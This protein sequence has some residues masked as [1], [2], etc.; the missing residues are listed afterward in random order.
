MGLDVE[1]VARLARLKL[2]TA[3]VELLGKQLESVLS[4][5]NVLK[6]VNIEGVPPTTHV[7]PLKNIFREDEVKPS[8]ASEDVLK[9]APRK[10]GGFFKVPPILKQ[11]S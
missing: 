2:N 7:L 11:K 1:Y 6:E 10:K 8:L 4:Y 9:N 5:I 3:E